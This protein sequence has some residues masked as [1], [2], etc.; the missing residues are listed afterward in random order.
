MLSVVGYIRF[1]KG[2][3]SDNKRKRYKNSRLIINNV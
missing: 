3:Q 1:F 2:S